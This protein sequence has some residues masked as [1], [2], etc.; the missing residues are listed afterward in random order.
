MVVARIEENDISRRQLIF[1]PPAPEAPPASHHHPDDVTVMKV[2]REFLYHPA[3]PIR[4]Y[5][6][7][8]VVIDEALFPFGCHDPHTS[9]RLS[10]YH[11]LYRLS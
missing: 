6:K 4:F 2:I 1:G 10:Y 3:E 11:A 9:P 7:I 5:L 8:A